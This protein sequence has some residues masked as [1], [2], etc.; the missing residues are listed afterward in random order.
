VG[1]TEAAHQSVIFS[2]S[3]EDIVFNPSWTI[4]RSILVKEILPSIRRQPGYLAQHHMEVIDA[5][6]QVVPENTVDWQQDPDRFPYRIRQVPGPDNALGR[7]KFLFPN[8]YSI[9]LHD[10]PAK[11]LF[12]ESRRTFSH[13]CIRVENPLRL[14]LFLLGGDSARTAARIDSMLATGQETTVKLSRHIPV[15]ITYFTAWVGRDGR[16]NF[17]DDIYGHDQKLKLLLIRD[18]N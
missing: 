2:E 16:L 8:T 1:E 18:R 3:L 14:A 12:E 13:G 17:R 10:T 11:S 9:Y 5:R 7:V 15:F 4:P 6:G